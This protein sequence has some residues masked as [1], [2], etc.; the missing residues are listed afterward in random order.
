MNNSFTQ[1]FNRLLVAS[2]KSLTQVATISGLDRAYVLRLSNGDKISPSYETVIRL[3]IALVFDASMIGKD[4]TVVEG[5]SELLLAA[6]YTSA[7][8]KMLER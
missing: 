5:L 7:P 4:P 2:G 6:A 8:A 3:F 1:V